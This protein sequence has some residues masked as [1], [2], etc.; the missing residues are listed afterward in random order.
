LVILTPIIAE[1]GTFLIAGLVLYAAVKLYGRKTGFAIILA[2]VLWTTPIETLGVSSGDYTYLGY[3]HLLAPNY[4][5]Y[6]LWVGLVPLWI[7]LGWFIVSL[8]SF[9]IFHEVLCP[10]KRALVCALFAGLL[11]VNVDLMIDPVASSNHLWIWIQPGLNLFGVP[12]YN[13]AGWFLMI[14]FFDLI[15][16]HTITGVRPIKPLAFLENKL[17]SFKDKL[18]SAITVEKRLQLFALRIVLFEIFVI[19]SLKTLAAL[20]GVV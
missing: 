1:A 11:A 3:Y 15:I 18:V 5:G 19:V 7:G 8:S 20:L 10:K 2:S 12:L 16:Y 6:L 9:M 4:P 17:F 13:F 14:L